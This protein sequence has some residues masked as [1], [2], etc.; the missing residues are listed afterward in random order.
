MVST[1]L[2]VAQLLG[3]LLLAGVLGTFW[4]QYRQ[5]YLGWWSMSFVALALYLATVMVAYQFRAGG[6]VATDPGMIGLALGYT[7]LGFLQLLTL[8]IGLHLLIRP[9]WSPARRPVLLLL[10]CLLLGALVTLPYAT[11][12]DGNLSRLFLRTGLRYL[13]TG[14]ALI[15]ASIGVLRA[16][17]PWHAGRWLVAAG[18]GL[19]GVLLA[20]MGTMSMP[21]LPTAGSATLGL[22]ARLQPV[23][24]LLAYQVIGLGLVIWL[25]AIERRRAE[26][27]DRRVL[28]LSRSDPLT[29]LPNDAGL[30]HALHAWFTAHP[31][32]NVLLAIAGL[33]NF[34]LV[35][36]TLGMHGGDAAL[37]ALGQRLTRRLPA[38]LHVGR[39]GGDQFLLFTA[40]DDSAL[41]R[42][43]DLQMLIHE[44]L[45]V[46]GQN[47]PLSASMGW[48][49]LRSPSAWDSVLREAEI[50]LHAAKM[51]GDGQCLGYSRDMRGRLQD[52]V[53][54]SDQ[55]QHAF[56]NDA[57]AVHLQ[58]L[59]DC[60]SGA[61]AG[62]EAL[63]RWP[64]PRRG[65]LGP[66]A[67]L[68]QLQT[69]RLMPRFDLMMLRRAITLLG[70]EQ[71]G[72][73]PRLAVNLSAESLEHP[74]LVDDVGELLRRHGVPAEQLLVEVTEGA[75]MRS[76]QGGLDALRRL[77]ELGV[78]VAVDDFGTGYSSLTYLKD[79]PAQWIKFDRAF[80]ASLGETERMVLEALVPLCHRL[81][82]RVVAEGVETQAQ[83][84]LARSLG[85]DLAQ[86][87]LLAR[88]TEADEA[89]AVWLPAE[90]RDQTR[91]AGLEVP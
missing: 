35:N 91:R 51:H 72:R 8:L 75:A 28:T 21:A 33:D 30:R 80:I 34:R 87:Y 70:S 25:L 50:A 89:L 22:L 10:A 48:S 60:R 14:L 73:I 55:V 44:R 66:G 52:W 54:L 41:E 57:F 85:F 47:V 32:Q 53:S 62:F 86:G 4:R 5:A 13:L 76:M 77:G 84:E 56:D 36:Q 46:G 69:L 31:G 18:L 90:S 64:H 7:T 9:E 1:S 42:L 40:D 61:L 19:Y 67:F 88:P 20:V 12:P 37:A 16:R 17:A 71:G 15:A 26:A 3:A 68:P 29:G 83:F 23:V 49:R 24:E 39:F 2:M 63:A 79:L 43:A 27:A 74:S 45:Q 65:L 82:R 11:A 81:G 38:G 78:A 6:S 58:P 59:F